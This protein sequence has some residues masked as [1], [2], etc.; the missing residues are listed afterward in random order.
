MLG[1]DRLAGAD[2]SWAETDGNRTVNSADDIDSWS[3]QNAPFP[4]FQKRIE[5]PVFGIP[6]EVVH[7]W[8]PV[9]GA[10]HN[11]H[12]FEGVVHNW[13]ECLSDLRS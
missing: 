2:G 3:F 11:W 12:H 9:E 4:R 1:V 8:H 6:A 13:H 10:V 5:N 7:N